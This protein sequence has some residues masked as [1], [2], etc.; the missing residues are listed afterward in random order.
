[1]ASEGKRCLSLKRKYENVES[2]LEKMKL[3][4]LSC[5]KSKSESRKMPF[6]KW[7]K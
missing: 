3:K 4:K 7:E 5:L 1:M 6:S 2:K